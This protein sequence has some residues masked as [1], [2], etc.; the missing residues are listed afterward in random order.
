MELREE[1]GKF[2]KKESKRG[3]G[4]GQ[5][6]IKTGGRRDEANMAERMGYKPKEEHKIQIK[7]G[8]NESLETRQMKDELR[9]KAVDFA[10]K[11]L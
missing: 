4:K 11:K 2:S 5:Q 9:S 10:T 3:E 6:N 1:V 8:A 7:I